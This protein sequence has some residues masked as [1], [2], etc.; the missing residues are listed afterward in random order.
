MDYIIERFDK[1]LLFFIIYSLV[2]LIFFKVLPYTFPFLLSLVFA[3]ILK[4][5]T[6]YFSKK[7]NINISISAFLTVISFF[8]L[9]IIFLFSILTVIYS[10]LISL[11]RSF[12]VYF[13]NYNLLNNEFILSL[14]K[15]YNNLDPSMIS[16]LQNYLGGWLS[17]L[18]SSSV[19][20][21]KL[22]ATYM[23]NFITSI[24]YM[25]MLIFFT[26]ISTYFITRDLTKNNNFDISNYIPFQSINLMVVFNETK[27]MILNYLISY[28]II[29]LIT[30]TV[31]LV[32]F[33]I[34]GVRYALVLSIICSIFDL[35]P[36]LGI[37]AVYLPI[38][39][40]YLLSKNFFTGIGLLILLLLVLIVRQIAEPKI[41]SSSLGVHPVAILASIFIGL[42]VSGLGGMLFCVFLVVFYNIL[43]NVKVL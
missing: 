16:Y 21:G 2:F 28:L 36:I 35:L 12:S 27:K 31:T 11:T 22:A 33:L 30:F 3:L 9:I 39:I 19:Y 40:V 6:L 4:S 15:Y 18:L 25:L 5:P 29:I 1:I 37:T 34:L 7:L 20:L 43:K 14:R 24:P 38:S 42:K 13:S 26:F 8:T 41:V 17:K 23:L 10:E 32:G